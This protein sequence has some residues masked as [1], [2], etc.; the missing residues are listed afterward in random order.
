MRLNIKKFDGGKR[1]LV[2]T[3]HK[4]VFSMRKNSVF[5]AGMLAVLLTFGLVL[6]GCPTDDDGGTGESITIKKLA[7]GDYPG[8]IIE[9]GRNDLSEIDPPGAELT[10]D[11]VF[12]VNGTNYS[13]GRVYSVPLI[14]A[15][16]LCVELTDFTFVE[17]TSYTVKVKY[18]KGTT[19]IKF[20]NGSEL[21]NFEIEGTIIAED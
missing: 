18:T 13:V 7:A 14:G 8:I 10:S 2:R 11:F 19:P 6:V 5:M 12:A 20:D 3:A 16:W 15:T 1:P 21:G 4:G 9:A 17:G